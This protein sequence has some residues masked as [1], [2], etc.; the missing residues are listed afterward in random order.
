MESGEAA[1]VRRPWLAGL[2]SVFL[3]GIVHV[4][5]GYARRGVLAYVLVLAAGVLVI[6]VQ[7][8]VVMWPSR[9]VVI[10]GMALG[11]G[12]FLGLIVL[13]AR[14]AHRL[15]R[16]ASR[17]RRR[18]AALLLLTAALVLSEV[19]VE[20]VSR[21]LVRAFKTPS[22]SMAPALMVGD[23]VLADMRTFGSRQP[24]AGDIV[25]LIHPKDPKQEFIKRVVAVARQTV[26]MRELKLYVDGTP[27]DEPFAVYRLGGTPLSRR[28]GPLTVPEGTVFVLGDNRDESADSRIWGPVPIANVTGLVRVIYWSWDRETG[29]VRWSRVGRPVP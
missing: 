25:V 23:H 27:V 5:L 20:P 26:E 14:D 18:G 1:P 7:V 21:S 29:S 8:A 24:G 16:E 3:P 2:L 10:G 6:G 28:V 17:P 4:Y 9:P 15:A 13:V 22:A 19:L 11:F 12:V